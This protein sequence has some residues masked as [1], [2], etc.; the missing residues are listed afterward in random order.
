MSKASDLTLMIEKKIKSKTP[1]QDNPDVKRQGKWI[2]SQ[3]KR[4][5]SWTK[6]YPDGSFGSIFQIG[7]EF[8]WDLGVDAAASDS[9]TDM[10]GTVATLKRAQEMCDSA[11]RFWRK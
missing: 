6:E 4:S 3:T 10:S 7:K 11:Y 9:S 8:N 2:K 1:V 5:K